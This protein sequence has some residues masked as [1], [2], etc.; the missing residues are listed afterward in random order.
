M[1]SRK[2]RALMLPLM[3]ARMVQN[4]LKLVPWFFTVEVGMK[5]AGITLFDH[6]V[7]HTIGVLNLREQIC[8][9]KPYYRQKTKIFF[10]DN[11]IS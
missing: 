3:S 11:I 1:C 7:S 6:K 5:I 10:K 2:Y 4:T 8:Y 9:T